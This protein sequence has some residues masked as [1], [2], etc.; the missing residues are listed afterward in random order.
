MFE[1]RY[2]YDAFILKML[3]L[4]YN[5]NDSIA[6]LRNC[7]ALKLKQLGCFFY[8]HS[9]L[10]KILIHVSYRCCA[11]AK[12]L[13]GK[14]LIKTTLWVCYRDFLYMFVCTHATHHNYY[15]TESDLCF[16]VAEKPNTMGVVEFIATV[17]SVILL[18]VTLPFSLF[19]CFKVSQCVLFSSF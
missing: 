1:A 5:F 9:K 2:F 11:D 12:Q 7:F 10:Q 3:A 13:L 14:Y 4:F 16:V 6:L 17:G 15:W 8:P 18:I 19:F